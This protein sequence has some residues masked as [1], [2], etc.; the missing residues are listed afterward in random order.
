ML[1][2]LHSVETQHRGIFQ[3]TSVYDQNNNSDKQGLNLIHL[4]SV[5]T[6]YSYSL[7]DLETREFSNSILNWSK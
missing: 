1:N 4:I 2:K 7:N 6:N 3:C 5:D